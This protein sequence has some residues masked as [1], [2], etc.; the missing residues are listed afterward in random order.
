MKKV[1]IIK[2]IF[3]NK[4]ARKI[5]FLG[6]KRLL[7]YFI[8]QR[9]FRINSHVPWPVHWSSVVTHPGKIKKNSELPYLGHHFGC[10][11]QANNGI[12][13]GINLRY[14]ANVHMISANHDLCNYEKHIK[15][16]PIRIGDN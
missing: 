2:K 4:L 1:D 16:K 8:M 13:V 3:P 7:Q 12:E 9:V 6:P 10:Y 14:G 15:T 5:I 11:I